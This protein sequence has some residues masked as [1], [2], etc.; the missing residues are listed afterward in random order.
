MKRVAVLVGAG[1]L[2]VVAVVWGLLAARGPDPNAVPTPQQVFDRTMSPFCTGVT[3]ESCTSNQA[4]ELRATIAEKIYEGET[5]RQINHFLLAN[6]P[7][8]VIGS[9]RNPF[10]WLVPAAAVL[11]GLGVV[12]AVMLRQPE[13]GSAGPGNGGPAAD[14]PLPDADRARLEADLRRFAEGVSE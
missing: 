7:S 3:L 5:N 11:A 8:T 14:P 9:P 10:A 12:A 2:V 13:P 6:Y 1:A 4:F